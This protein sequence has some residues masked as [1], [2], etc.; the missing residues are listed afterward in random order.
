MKKSILPKTH[1]MRTQNFHNASDKLRYKEKTGEVRSID[2]GVYKISV[3]ATQSSDVTL[4]YSYQPACQTHCWQADSTVI[5]IRWA[6]LNDNYKAGDHYITHTKKQRG[7]A[8]RKIKV[9]IKN[10]LE[11]CQKRIPDFKKMYKTRWPNP[12]RH[13][14]LK[15]SQHC[16]HTGRHQ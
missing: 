10:G 2:S 15:Q 14:L 11:L 5:Q 13:D 3:F 16:L 4:H 1:L 6:G 7:E 8:T 9:S 12:S